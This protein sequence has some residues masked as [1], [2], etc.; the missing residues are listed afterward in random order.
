MKRATKLSADFVASLFEDRDG[1]LFLRERPRAMFWCDAVH[2]NWNA[3]YA[4]RAAKVRAIGGGHL[5]VRY[6]SHCLLV[7][8]VLWALHFGEWPKGEID[9][10]NGVNTDNRL[11]NLRDTTKSENMR[12]QKL[13][14]DSTSGFPGVHFCRD[15]KNK[16]W[17]ARVGLNN[18]WKTL[19]YFATREE[20]VACRR[21]EQ[22][23]YGFSDIHGRVAPESAAA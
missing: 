20:A 7:H 21:T 11:C 17:V 23:K 1:V 9:H 3:R 6:A 2:R 10:I 14:K 15:K 22:G 8:R 4:G 19:G 13:R 12:N 5:T 18:T 16:P